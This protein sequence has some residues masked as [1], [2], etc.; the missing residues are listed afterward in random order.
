MAFGRCPELS[1][2][3]PR[4]CSSVS[5]TLGP[6]YTYH[7]LSEIGDSIRRLEVVWNNPPLLE[8]AARVFESPER[9]KPM[10]QYV[11][12]LVVPKGCKENYADWTDVKYGVLIEGDYEAEGNYPNQ[13]EWYVRKAQ[14]SVWL[15]NEPKKVGIIDVSQDSQERDGE[16]DRIYDLQ[17]RVVTTPQRGRLYIRNQKK[18]VWN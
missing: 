15:Y 7:F 13:Y 2:R 4:F 12:T 9:L 6:Q 8:E 18:I 10:F 11:D 5:Q 16:S 17:G 14:F 1:I 3:L